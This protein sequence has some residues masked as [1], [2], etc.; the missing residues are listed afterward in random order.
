MTTHLY[1]ILPDETAGALQPNLSGLDG[2]PVRALR[3]ERMVAW[4][5][6]VEHEVP[7]SFEGVR[8]E[9]A[10]A[11]VRAHDAVV[12][13]AL[14]TGSTPVPARFGQR[15]ASDDACRAALM[16]QGML[17]ESLVSTV[18]GMVEMTLILT[19]STRRMLRD[20][21][22][23]LPDL[24]ESQ[25]TGM[26][27]AYLNALRSREAATGAVRRAMDGLAR[28]LLEATKALVRD[29]KV[30]DQA[31]R[32]PLRTLSQLIARGRVDEYQRTVN[33]VESGREFRFLVIG[34]RAPY[35]FCSLGGAGGMH[36]MKLAD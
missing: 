32:L 30:H 25:T 8:A 33:A 13:A 19:P 22:P 14:D 34:P 36:G 26:G 15:F 23:V 10:F 2:A 28:K 18:Q 35:S 4:V 11:S 12:E 21:E 3:V 7:V 27:K 29:T 31:T 5:S 17:L 16:K 20:L 9:E 1:C 6:D 24:I